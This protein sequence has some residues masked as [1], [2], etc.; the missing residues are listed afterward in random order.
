MHP[1]MLGLTGTEEQVKAASQAYK[2]YYKKQDGDGFY[3]M[4]HSSFSYLV[5][6]ES[7]FE[8]FYRRD[9]TAEELAD[10]AA[11]FLRKLG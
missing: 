2:T 11:C 7:G 1:D 3:L 9:E 6:P 8:N 5:L 4:D 10:S